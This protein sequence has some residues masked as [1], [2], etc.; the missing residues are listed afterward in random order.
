[1]NIERK[2][3]FDR[4][5]N[6]IGE[7]SDRCCCANWTDGIE[8]MVWQAVLDDRDCEIGQGYVTREELIFIKS[9]AERCDSWVIWGDLT[10]SECGI[11]LGLWKLLWAKNAGK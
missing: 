3:V 8:K 4:L 1:V 2:Y 6:A 7:I 11:D 10:S 5:V 9:L